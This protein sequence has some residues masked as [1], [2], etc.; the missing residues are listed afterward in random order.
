M[1]LL[2]I[3][4]LARRLNVSA[5]TIRYYEEAGLISPRKHSDNQY[6]LF[7]ERDVRRLQTILSLRAVGISVED[8]RS[9]LAELDRGNEDGVLH[10]LELQ[11]SMM[12]SQL[13]EL[14][15][16]IETAD[17]MIQRLKTNG[18]LAWG[19]IFEWTEG[20]KRLRELR[21][22][23]RD[24]WDFDRQ[25]DSH[26]ERVRGQGP[27]DEGRRFA[28]YSTALQLVVDWIDP[29]PGERGLDIGTG[30]G[31]L[32]GLFL[33]KGVQMAGIDQSKEMLRR[34][35]SKFPS[36]ETKLGNFLAIPYLDHSFD[37]AASSYA[38][39]HLD[40][41][42]KPLA[43]AEIRRVLKPHGTICI[44]DLMFENEDARGRYLERLRRDGDSAFVAWIESESF[45]DRSRLLDWL[46]GE[47]YLTQAKQ[48]SEL[49]H[50][51]RAVPVRRGY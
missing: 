16:N 40:E 24:H 5:R 10:A 17:R 21:S 51:I 15:N 46:N 37:F 33:E 11:R 23:W 42:Q 9:L 19:D 1:E 28:D 14:K 44:A 6:R 25:A 2:H 41:E 32:A 43:L 13:V 26:D 45:A 22:N 47:G 50:V 12:F 35:R 20:A 18:S 4:Q 3:K 27:G 36:M 7:D 39:H 48:V 30:T 34:C 49:L 29:R 38:L 8:T 31:N